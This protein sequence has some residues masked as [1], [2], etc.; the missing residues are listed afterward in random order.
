MPLPFVVAVPYPGRVLLI[1]RGGVAVV[2]VNHG[3]GAGRQ[4][5]DLAP[6]NNLAR[7]G[8]VSLNFVIQL[9]DAVSS[10]EQDVSS[11]RLTDVATVRDRPESCVGNGEK[12]RKID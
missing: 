12:N 4:R 6:R 1:G 9:G 10:G 8:I 2:D 11:I 3:V 7:R 5:R